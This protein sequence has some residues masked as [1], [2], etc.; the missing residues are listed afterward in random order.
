MSKR[1]NAS[2]ADALERVF[3][4]QRLPAA[5]RL[6]IKRMIAARDEKLAE[7]RETVA[8]LQRQNDI[9]E[10]RVA[11]MAGLK[12]AKKLRAW[13]KPRR[14]KSGSADAV[15]LISDVHCEETVR[16]EEV[17]HQNEYTLDIAD[18][19]IRETFSRALHL[20]EDARNLANVRQLKLWIGGDLIS[21]HIHDELRENNSLTP[22]AACRWIKSRLMAGIELLHSQGGF[23]DILIVTNHG[24]HGRDTPKN[25]SAGEKDRSYEYDLYLEMRDATSGLKNVRW[26]I[27]EGAHNYVDIQG[28]VAR[29]HHGHKVKYGGGVGGVYIPLNKATYAWNQSK[30]A[31]L[32]FCG[33]F[34]QYTTIGRNTLMNGSIIGYSPFAIDIKAPYEPALQAMAVVDRERGMTRAMPIF[35]R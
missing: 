16:A 32:N 29:F 6:K 13:S 25:R 3:E 5:E 22:L 1:K 9:L 7:A 33:H 23:D 21:G 26:Q 20:V 34:H 4:A 12:D 19:S 18:R 15:V 28:H 11:L 27:A 31:D 17:N 35:C 14:V 30:K 24:N 2:E 8:E 10:S